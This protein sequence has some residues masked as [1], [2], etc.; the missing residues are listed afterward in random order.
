[1]LTV[2]IVP[3]LDVR[4]GRVVK[5]V[6]F[7]NLRDAGDPV[8]RALAY[9]EAGV[10]TA[11]EEIGMMEVHD[12]F[13]ITE[14]VTYEDLQISP[15]GRAA[16]VG[17]LLTCVVP[18]DGVT[19]KAVEQGAILADR[20][21]HHIESVPGSSGQYL[22]LSIVSRVRLSNSSFIHPCLSNL[23]LPPAILPFPN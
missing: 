1:M 2:R 21:W 15:H 11:R 19:L 18:P 16:D 10:E 22:K 8:E 12:C 13:S 5:G 20:T 23:P 3:C 9:A 17:V 14:L 7:Q 6:R 4:D